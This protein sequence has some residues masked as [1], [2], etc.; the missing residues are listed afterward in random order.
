[1]TRSRRSYA[2]AAPSF[3]WTA[4]MLGACVAILT[5]ELVVLFSTRHAGIPRQLFPGAFC[6]LMALYLSGQLVW[7]ARRGSVSWWHM[8]VV[9]KV[10]HAPIYRVWFVI[11]LLT[12]VM[13]A[14]FA[15]IFL[16]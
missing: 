1:M 13:F 10:S 14:L 4:F 7:T 12:V 6:L 16:R 8:Q 3:A 9:S 15:V 2:P 5:I 11:H